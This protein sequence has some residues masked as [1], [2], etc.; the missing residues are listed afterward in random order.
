M[1]VRKGSLADIATMMVLVVPKAAW[2]KAPVMGE[3]AVG[4]QLNLCKPQCGQC[5]PR[6]TPYVLVDKPVS[7]KAPLHSLRLKRHRVSW[8]EQRSR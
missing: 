1:N 7:N 8:S 6:L 4:G 2:G 3:G 5:Q